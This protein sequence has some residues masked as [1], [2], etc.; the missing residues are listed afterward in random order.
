MG[1]PLKFEWNGG[2]VPLLSRKLA[3]SLKR[4]KITIDD[5][6]EVAHALST[7]AKINDFG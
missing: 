7:G 2:G 4:G 1:T 5:Q 3:I 6:Y